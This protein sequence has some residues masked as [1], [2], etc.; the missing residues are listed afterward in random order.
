MA[1]NGQAQEES[2]KPV[3]TILISQPKPERSPYYE[4][5]QKYGLKIDWRQFIHV[6]GVPAKEFRKAKV[7]PDEYTAV[8]LTSKNAIDHY[9]RICDEMRIKVSPDMKYFCLSE[10]IA[11][12]LQKFIVYRKRKVFV[13]KRTIQDLGPALKKHKKERFLLP[14]SNLGAK[15]VS[16]YLEEQKFDWQDAMMYQTVS[17]DLS[18]LSDV[19]YD[20]LVFFSPLGI[21]SLYENFPDFKQNDTR[22]A[23]FGNSTG[24]EVEKQGLT[25]NI[26]V[27]APGV[28][29]MATALELYLQK[30]NKGL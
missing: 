17:S 16:A 29:S 19:T 28:T 25:I 11:N 15:Q 4:L 2:Y 27:P 18:D 26:K 3:K 12:Y 20:V 6:E 7:K 30:S 22:L 14:C 13:G 23:I 21:K 24:K 9:F 8:I 10:A 5:E 1:A